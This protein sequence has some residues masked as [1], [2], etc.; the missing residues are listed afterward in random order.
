METEAQ[1]FLKVREQ[2]RAPFITRCGGSNPKAYFGCG[3]FLPK[4]NWVRRDGADGRGGHLGN[5]P[6]C[7]KCAEQAD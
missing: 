6:L 7:H 4:I 3:C 2:E 5:V 1:F